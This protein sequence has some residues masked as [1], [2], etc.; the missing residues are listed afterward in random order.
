MNRLLLSARIV[1]RQALRYTPAGLPA[2]DVVLEHASDLV[3]EG[4]ARKV[5]LEMK[6]RAIGSAVRPVSALAIG[7]EAD[8]SGFLGSQRNGR[9]IVFHILE[10]QPRTRSDGDDA[11]GLPNPQR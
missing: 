11:G 2:L 4:Q 6:A 9:G 1:E 3:Q 7:D 8:F 5:R 10:L